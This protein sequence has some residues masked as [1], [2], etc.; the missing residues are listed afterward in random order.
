MYVCVYTCM[1]ILSIYIIYIYIYIYRAELAT[2][3]KLDKVA[4]IK[5][6]NAQLVAI[7][8]YVHFDNN[9]YLNDS[10]TRGMLYENIIN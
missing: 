2:K 5:K 7:K 10:V 8:K 9:N 1:Y 6:L 3:T 4:E